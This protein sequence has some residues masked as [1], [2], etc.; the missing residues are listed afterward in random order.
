MTDTAIA[1]YRLV[2]VAARSSVELPLSAVL[3]GGRIQVY[4]E[5]E[6]EGLL[7]LQFQGGKIRLTAGKY[8]GLIPL[9]P[10]ITVDVRPKLPVRNL[11]RV[12]DQA[13]ASLGSVALDRYYEATDDQGTTILEFLLSNL[14]NSLQSVQEN[15]Y[16]KNYISQVDAGALHGRLLAGQTL[17]SLWSRGERHKV[18]TESFQQSVDVAANRVIKFALERATA[19][20]CRVRPSSPILHKANRTHGNFPRSVEALLHNDLKICRAALRS[21]SLPASRAYYYRPLE[22]SELL[23]GNSAVSLERTGED[24]QLQT[25]ILNFEEVFENYLRHILAARVPTGCDVRDGNGEGARPLYDDRADPPAQPDIVLEHVGSQPVIVEVKYKDK[26]D[27]A[28]VNQVVTYAAAY[29]ATNVVLVHQAKTAAQTGAQLRGKINGTNV[30]TYGFDL[31]AHDLEGQE[32]A[33]ATAMSAFVT[34][35]VHMAAA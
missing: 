21:R 11:A 17:K 4:P 33:F 23:L 5:V 20:L 28:D 22:I 34:E 1:D 24:V 2:T 29:R 30:F 19:T 15:G 14:V 8:V 26:P 31:S 35:S 27:R 10:D 16:L 7:F 9:T 12:L 18:V 25:F 6:S 13:R 3:K 32:A